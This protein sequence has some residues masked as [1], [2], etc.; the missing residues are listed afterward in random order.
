M[1]LLVVVV[2][3]VVVIKPLTV[4]LMDVQRIFSSINQISTVPPE[5]CIQKRATPC[6]ER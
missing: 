3:V 6:V 5:K 1:L 4:K 2:V